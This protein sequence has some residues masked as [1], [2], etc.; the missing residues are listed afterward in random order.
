MGEE[1]KPVVREKGT[2]ERRGSGEGEKNIFI[3]QSYLERVELQKG[4][5]RGLEQEEKE[6]SLLN[7]Q[8]RISHGTLCKLIRKHLC[9]DQLVWVLLLLLLLLREVTIIVVG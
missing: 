5:Q 7:L 6:R 2:K 9:S 4:R 8:H 1:G 3:S